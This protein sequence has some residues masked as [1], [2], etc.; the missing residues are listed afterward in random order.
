MDKQRCMH[1]KEIYDRNELTWINDNYG[2]PF[3]KVCHKCYD[4]VREDIR[5]NNYGDELTHEELYGYGD[6]LIDDDW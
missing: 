4:E 5:G 3:K 1:C 6:E 2:I